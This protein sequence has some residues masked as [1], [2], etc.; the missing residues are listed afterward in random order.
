MVKNK[1]T[2]KIQTTRMGELEATKAT[3]T[4][5]QNLDHLPAR[6]PR[7]VSLPFRRLPASEKPTYPYILV[8]VLCALRYRPAVALPV[9]WSG[10]AL[11]VLS[12][13]AMGA[14]LKQNKLS[15]SSWM[16]FFLS[17]IECVFPEGKWAALG[18]SAIPWQPMA[19]TRQASFPQPSSKNQFN[20]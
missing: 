3:R 20:I 2:Y 19:G 4:T 13:R 10:V 5:L 9:A 12:F 6:N 16:I 7:Q 1:D 14:L 8:V 17:F 15:C 18:G 11:L